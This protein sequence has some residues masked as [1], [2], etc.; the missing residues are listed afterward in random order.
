M[1]NTIKIDQQFKTAMKLKVAADIYF[2]KFKKFPKVGIFHS[3]AELL[4]A[5]LLEADPE[6][7]DFTPQPMQVRVKS[8]RYIPDFHYIK[9]NKSYIAELKPRGEFNEEKKLI[10]EEIFSL[11]DM[12]FEVI[13]NEYALKQEIK[14][15]NWL[16]VLRVILSS[17][18]DT[19]SN[20]ELKLMADVINGSVNKFGDVVDVGNRFGT[21]LEE[22]ALYRLI[23][24][25]K[26]KADLDKQLIHIDTRIET[27][28]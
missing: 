20:Q 6:V 12:Q 8:K 5:A 23:Y 24:E 27:C 18:L 17:N 22:L 4:F 16:Q 11:Q 26:L 1:T 21:K 14:A 10:C 3:Y 7:S 9:N 15:V 2:Q 13:S 28:H 25:G 19:T